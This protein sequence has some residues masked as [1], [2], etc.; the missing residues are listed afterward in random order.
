MSRQDIGIFLFGSFVG[1]MIN[2]LFSKVS[3]RAR[4][5]AIETSFKKLE[6]AH[7][8]LE[9][10]LLESKQVTLKYA[11]QL[12]G[13]KQI[14]DVMELYVSDDQNLQILKNKINKKQ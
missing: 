3:E 1:G 13:I 12:A 11:Q 4:I 7:K 14:I 9:L 8:A 6:I 5:T 10:E 2:A